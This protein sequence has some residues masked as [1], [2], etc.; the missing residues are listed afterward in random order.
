MI[1]KGD[2]GYLFDSDK[3]AFEAYV[4]RGGGLVNIHD[5]LCAPAP[6]YLA[7]L[8]GGAKKHGEVN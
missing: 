4:K 3:A 5:S 6:G 8:L 2:A 7:M 1:Y